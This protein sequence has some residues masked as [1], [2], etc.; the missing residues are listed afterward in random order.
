VSA[1]ADATIPG[2]LGSF[3]YDDE[4]TPAQR[5]QLVK[6]GIFTGYM[7]SR[8]YA[9]ALGHE[10]TGQARADGWQRLPLVR[11]TNICLE[12]G[13][14]S[15]AEMIDGTKR[16]ILVDINRG[17]SIDDQRMN[18][19]FQTEIGWEI[20]DGKVGRMLK[21]CTYQSDTPTFWGSLDALGGPSE[22]RLHGVPS[23]NKG[24]PLQ[25]AHVGH[26]TVPGRFRNVQVGR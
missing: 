15:L 26:G 1:Y 4:G 16:G 5:T 25:V 7:S 11:M 9:G 21:N 6:D 12:P 2:A 3:K 24:E 19:R 14:S 10:S 13:E 20:R 17:F 8:E 18:F 23:C 22:W